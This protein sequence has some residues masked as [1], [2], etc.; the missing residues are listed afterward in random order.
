MIK[1]S[2]EMEE[3]IL[4]IIDNIYFLL[5]S[6]NIGIGKL[7]DY[8][9]LRRGYFARIKSNPKD[10]GICILLETIQF[11]N[12]N[13]IYFNKKPITLDLLTS[14]DL[15]IDQ[16]NKESERLQNEI[17]LIEKRKQDLLKNNVSYKN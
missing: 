16:L 2:Y 14:N 6:N 13:K 12:N 8:I 15:L 10:I 9:N 5:N 1:I 11:M 3:N 17:K 7:E 4:N